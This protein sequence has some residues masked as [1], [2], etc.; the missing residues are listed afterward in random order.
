LK[1]WIPLALTDFLNKIPW[2]RLIL[3]MISSALAENGYLI[4]IDRFKKITCVNAYIGESNLGDFVNGL[5]QASPKK[6]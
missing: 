1:N 6:K 2:Q 5:I 3:K 4:G